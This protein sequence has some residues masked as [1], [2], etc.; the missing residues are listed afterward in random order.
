M[1]RVEAGV[2]E[3]LTLEEPFP[4]E[5]T[6]LVAIEHPRGFLSPPRESKHAVPLCHA[7]ITTPT[8]RGMRSMRGYCG[9]RCKDGTHHP[10][11][12]LIC[13]AIPASTLRSNKGRLLKLILTRTVLVY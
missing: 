9:I 3:P 6:V 13:S 2:A 12:P 7:Q 5:L 4:D 8:Y 1:D 10:V 11:L